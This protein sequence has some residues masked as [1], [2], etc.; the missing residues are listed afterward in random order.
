[1][2]DQRLLRLALC[3]RGV[4]RWRERSVKP[5]ESY[6]W[7]VWYPDLDRMRYHQTPTQAWT[8]TRCGAVSLR[9][10]HGPTNTTDT[11]YPTAEDLLRGL[12]AW[13]LDGA[14]LRPQE[15]PLHPPTGGSNVHHVT[16]EARR[17]LDAHVDLDR[18][19]DAVLKPVQAGREVRYVVDT[20]DSRGDALPYL[21]AA[22]GHGVIA[23]TPREDPL[24]SG[25]GKKG[26][27]RGHA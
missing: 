10:F 24:F 13:E 4:H 27:G 9:Y 7:T 1:M 6:V 14:P 20:E 26:R 12:D 23:L 17:G 3:G 11:G 15:R 8:C 22:A 21:L 2:I 5:Y 25:E 19:L 18:L 16:V